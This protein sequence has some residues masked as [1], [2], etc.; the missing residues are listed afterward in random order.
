[1]MEP[2]DEFISRSEVRDMI[3]ES[4]ADAMKKHNRN[5]SIISACIGVILLAFYTHGVIAVV[6]K[7]Q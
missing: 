5:A 1:M 2:G 7:I 3:D 4:I 6:D